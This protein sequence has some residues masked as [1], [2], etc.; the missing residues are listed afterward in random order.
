[1]SF[2]GAFLLRGRAWPA[3]WL[4]W[5]ALT[6]ALA[7]SGPAAAAQVRLPAP[8]GIVEL[9]AKQQ[10]KEGDLFVAD[11]EVDIRYQDVRLRADHVEYSVLTSVALAR[12]HVQFDFGS[13]H[14]DA[15]QA[16]YNVRSGRGTFEHVRGSVQLERR[17]NPAILITPNPLY[18]EAQ[19]VERTGER[20]YKIRGAWLTVCAPDRPIWKF[21][22]PH[23]TL[24]VDKSVALVNANFRLFRVPLIYLPYATAPASRKLRQ[25]G[26]LLPDFSNTTRK[27]F[28]VGEAYYWAPADWVDLTF[29]A[30]LLSRRGWS[31]NGEFRVRPWEN[32]RLAASYFGVVDRGL[33]EGPG[34]A[35]VAQVGHRSQFEFDALLPDGWRAVADINTLT[36]LT[37]R[38]AFAETF[39]EAVNSEVRS[40]AFATNHFRGFSLNF[41]AENYKNFLNAQNILSAQQET[42]VLLRTAPGVRFGAVE[43]AP[44]KRWPIYFG[45]GAFADAVHRSEPCTSI[46]LSPCTDPGPVPFAQRRFET[47]AAVQRTEIA[48]RVTVPLRWGPWLGVT[49]TFVLRTTRYGSQLLSGTIVGDS[50]RRTTAE[51][52][53]DLRPPTLARVWNRPATKWKHA[54]EPQVIY[55][56]VN[57]VN[58][59]GRFIRFDENDT[60]TDT[61]EFEYGLTQRLY[62]RAGEGQ[63][64]EMVTWRVAQKYYF[65]PTF[66]GALVPGQRNVFQALYTI[67]PFAFADTPRRFSPIVSD[68]RVT[69]GGRYDAEF[70]M[71]YDTVRGKLTTA[72]TLLKMRPYREF[73]VTL[74]HFALRS[75]PALQPKSN[76]IRALVGY[77]NMNRRGWNTSFGFS[78]DI[79]QQFLQNQLVQVSYNGSC[80]G[81]AFEYRR[82][83]LGTVR[84][85]NQFRVALIIANIGTFG[86]LRREE[87]I[88]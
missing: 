15:D 27:G 19:E 76:Q 75:S 68:L 10:R 82:L 81:I 32:V 59:F 53:V 87:K 9:E 5:L 4:P 1:M 30:Q 26:F 72:G 88:F 20:T 64:E 86:N 16:R 35:R 85:E 83:A 3:A 50:V 11:G 34:G 66:G 23:A 51:V 7:A 74:A 17:P 62:R 12:G 73:F 6:V 40:A 46:R 57:G 49:P 33:R 22:A 79:R 43:Q 71:E 31:Q 77:G 2:L 60:L 28:V 42:A 63:A 84:S 56:Y 54:I 24:T 70:R 21:Y 37:F 78:Y 52:A 41:A 29:G 8:G 67:T 65:D 61:N 80:C 36:S 14:L 48:P 18:F 45:F 38:L 47:A 44:W 39:R 13:Q 25:S 55:R 58:R 69:P